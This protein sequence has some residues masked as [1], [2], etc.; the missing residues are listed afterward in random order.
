MA[1]SSPARSSRASLRA[2]RRS[3]FT[4][5]PERFGP[6]M[7]ENHRGGIAH[8]RGSQVFV[9]MPGVV[10][11]AESM[12]QDIHRKLDPSI[13][14]C[15]RKQEMPV[16]TDERSHP[17]GS[18][19][20]GLQPCLEIFGNRDNASLPSFG[21]PAFHDDLRFRHLRPIERKEFACPKA[22]KDFYRCSRQDVFRTMLKKL[23]DLR[24]LSVVTLASTRRDFSI[25]AVGLLAVHPC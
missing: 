10:V 2:S 14:G 5:S 4:R 12:T 13:R 15:L 16:S 21:I 3:V 7:A 1:L 19:S 8:L 23:G 25:V 20:I 22:A 17:P 6:I 11:R 18:L 9:A 24:R